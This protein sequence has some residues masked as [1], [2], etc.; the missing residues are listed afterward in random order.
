MRNNINLL[1]EN[2]IVKPALPN[3]KHSLAPEKPTSGIP[4]QKVQDAISALPVMPN[5]LDAS[6][7]QSEGNIPAHI[8]VGLEKIDT[9]GV[10]GI[11]DPVTERIYLVADNIESEQEAKE[12]WLHEQVGHHGLRGIMD[13]QERNLLLN[14]VAL[15]VGNTELRSIAERY[16]LDLQD[17]SQR[18]QAAEEYLAQ[19]A[20][21]LFLGESL[22]VKA[23]RA[24]KKLVAFMKKALAKF[25]IVDAPDTLVEDVLADSVSYL[26]GAGSS[27]RIIAKDGQRYYL[28]PQAVMR[29]PRLGRVRDLLNVDIESTEMRDI[30]D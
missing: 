27:T 24:W 11:Y 15:S 4:A 29:H 21:K 13:E 25:G 28:V 14:Q 26:R 1:T 2:E 20:E 19:V 10:R 5:A 17:K 18:Q 7:V 8:E 16:G 22:S 30:I 6:V 12:I 3:N 9:R 23:A